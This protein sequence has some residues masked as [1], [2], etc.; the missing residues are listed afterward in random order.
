MPKKFEEREAERAARKAE[1]EARLEAMK[2]RLKKL[3][4]MVVEV[5]GEEGRERIRRIFFATLDRQR[6]SLMDRVAELE[7]QKEEFFPDDKWT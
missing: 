5:R 6:Q 2:P 4:D 7:S 3:D 1:R